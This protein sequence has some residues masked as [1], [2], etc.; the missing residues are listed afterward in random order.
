MDGTYVG[1]V[2]VGFT[3]KIRR[4]VLSVTPPFSCHVKARGWTSGGKLRLPQVLRII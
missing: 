1:S 4:E 3:K 2:T